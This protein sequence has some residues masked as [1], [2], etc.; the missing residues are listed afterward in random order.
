M[1]DDPQKL[2]D[3]GE[4]LADVV[5]YAVAMANELGLDLATTLQRKI[6]KNEQ[7]YP[8]HEYRGR[9]GPEDAGG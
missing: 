9:Y 3:I 2:S 1:K 8:A 7:K 5:C 6:A 4:E